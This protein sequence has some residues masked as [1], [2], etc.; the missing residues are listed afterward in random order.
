MPKKPSRKDVHN[1]KKGNT[2]ANR[3]HW[4]VQNKAC[5]MCG[6]PAIM[7]ARVFAPADE[8]PKIHLV[9]MAQKTGGKVPVVNTKFGQYV[10]IGEAAAC[11]KHKTDLER[12]AAKHPDPWFVEFDYGPDPTNKQVIGGIR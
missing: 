6:K 8:I 5:T 9:V 12:Q 2:R 7:T 11:A 3:F 1:F 4:Q 10:R